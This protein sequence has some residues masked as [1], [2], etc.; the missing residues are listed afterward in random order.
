MGHSVDFVDLFFTFIG[1][2]IISFFTSYSRF[3]HISYFF[4]GRASFFSVV[5]GF[6]YSLFLLPLILV[7]P[8]RPA[9]TE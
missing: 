7:L 8:N 3:A 5:L 9:H 1:I 4:C 6:C 2:M